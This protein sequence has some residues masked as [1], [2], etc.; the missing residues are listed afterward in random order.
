[1]TLNLTK[2]ICFFD[3]ETTGININKDRIVEICVHKI[4]PDQSSQTKTYRLNPTI[5]IPLE[6]SLVHGI[7]DKDVK[8]C[9]TFKAIAGELSAFIGNS[10][11]AGYNSNK[12]D[13]PI[14]VE[15]FLRAD[16]DFD[17]KNRRLVDV[18]NIFHQMEQRTLIA[19]YKFY[20]N[21]K[22][23]GAHG[24][25]ADTLATYEILLAQLERYKD[26]PFEDRK[27]QVSFPVVNDIEALSVFT[28]QQKHVDYAGTM[29]YNDK[30]QE[31]FNIGKHKGR[32][33]SEVFEYEPSYYAWM[34]DA[35][36]SLSTKRKLT[37]IRLR[38]R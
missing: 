2:P 38:N 4:N 30:G 1:M 26:V 35:D 11:L 9:P 8:D 14:L 36:F 23:E 21:K 18:Q 28:T 12:F 25:E 20:C 15:E 34:M 32:L 37:E 17:M 22:L 29:V 13:V 16:V 31:V 3:L 5:T 33:V 24:A 10:D 6:A 27:G 19:A 7:Y